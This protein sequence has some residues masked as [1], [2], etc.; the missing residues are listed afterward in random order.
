[1]N[2]KTAILIFETI[3]IVFCGCTIFAFIAH[4]WKEAKKEEDELK[5]KQN[6]EEKT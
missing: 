6:E 2:H 1:M 4:F 5:S 3:S